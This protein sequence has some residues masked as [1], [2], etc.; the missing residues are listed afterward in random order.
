MVVLNRLEEMQFAIRRVAPYVTRTCIV[1]GGSSDGTIEWLQSK[2]CRDM[3]VD[4]KV[5]KQFRYA[6]GNHTPRERNQYLQMAGYDGWILV[7][8]S[9]EFIEEEAC[10]NLDNLVNMAANQGAIGLCLRAHDIWEYEDGRVYDNVSDYWN[11]MM[12]KGTP[13]QTYVGHTHSHIHLPGVNQKWVKSG[14][15]YR[16]TKTERMMWQ[17]SNFLY[18]TTS[19]NADNVTND[20]TWVEFHN[21][22][23]KYGHYDWHE[24]NKY[25]VN[26]NLPKE[27]KDYFIA[28]K[29]DENPELRAWFVDYF[30]FKH[31]EENVDKIGNVDMEWDYAV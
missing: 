29:D 3:N 30:I 13:G 17:N 11:P 12:W 21:L 20:D 23:Q 5:S 26:G 19:K 24:F 7:S 27:I 1:D 15:E 28:K 16:H 31:P 4:F 25:M 8:D 9:D 14:Y 22:M 6:V 18:W 10:K 2:E